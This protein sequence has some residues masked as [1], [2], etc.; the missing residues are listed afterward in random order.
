MRG[1]LSGSPLSSVFT[2]TTKPPMETLQ[3]LLELGAIAFLTLTAFLL[4]E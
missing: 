2:L 3:T 1:D 4:W